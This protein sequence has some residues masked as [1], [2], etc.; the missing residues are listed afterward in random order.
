M[1][2]LPPSAYGVATTPAVPTIHWPKC[3]KC[4]RTLAE[5]LTPPY[6]IR[7][8]RCRLVN[9]VGQLPSGGQPTRRAPPR[10]QR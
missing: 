6:S 2:T 8:K 1:T 7:C 3:W 5:Y 10:S 4:Q 9:T